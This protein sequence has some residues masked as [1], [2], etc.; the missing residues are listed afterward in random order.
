[1]VGNTAPFQVKT[2]EY[3][4]SADRV[5]FI[6]QSSIGVFKPT[7][8]HGVDQN[9]TAKRQTCLAVES[10]WK[11]SNPWKKMEMHRPMIGL[12]SFTGHWKAPKRKV[13]FENKADDFIPGMC[14]TRFQPKKIPEWSGHAAAAEPHLHEVRKADGLGEPFQRCKNMDW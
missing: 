11:H 7:P 10:Q 9:H 6:N 2:P 5:K 12:L 8:M 1:M 13:M 3:V 14:P 4:C